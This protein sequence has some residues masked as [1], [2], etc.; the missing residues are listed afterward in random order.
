ML[1]AFISRKN[2][3][4]HLIISAEALQ[5]DVECFTVDN[6]FNGPF[7]LPLRLSRHSVQKNTLCNIT[8][9]WFMVVFVT[10]DKISIMP[11]YSKLCL[12]FNLPNAKILI[13]TEK[14]WL[15]NAKKQ[16]NIIKHV[17]ALTLKGRQPTCVYIFLPL[18]M[19]VSQKCSSSW[20]TALDKK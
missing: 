9:F 13:W 18:K 2:E 3:N 19:F 15:A 7:L 12:E 4:V 11:P 20:Y 5:W 1:M 8:E 6:Q 17:Q 14:A 16:L 10:V